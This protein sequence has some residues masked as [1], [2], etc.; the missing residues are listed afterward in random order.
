MPGLSFGL[1]Q[2]DDAIFSHLHSYVDGKEKICNLFA[3]L[4]AETLPHG[5]PRDGVRDRD[6]HNC[7]VAS[8]GNPVFWIP[9][10]DVETG[11]TCGPSCLLA[12]WPLTMMN[13]EHIYIYISPIGLNLDQAQHNTTMQGCHRSRFPMLAPAVW[14]PDH[15][16]WPCRISFHICSIL[17]GDAGWAYLSTSPSSP[18][19]FRCLKHPILRPQPFKTIKRFFQWRVQ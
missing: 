19:H 13:Q 1:E 17:D 15:G 12:C 4:A 7:R 6:L 8:D 9:R 16:I 3:Q 10:T 5:V 2:R 14:K 11:S 18:K